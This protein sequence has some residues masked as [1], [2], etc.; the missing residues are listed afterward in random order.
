[1]GIKGPQSSR[2]VKESFPRTSSP[3]RRNLRL[4]LRD[5]N[6]CHS[7]RR[8]HQFQTCHSRFILHQSCCAAKQTYWS[9][10][11]QLLCQHGGNTA[12]TAYRIPGYILPIS[13][14]AHLVEWLEGSVRSGQFKSKNC[15]SGNR[16]GRHRFKQ[17]S[18]VLY[19]ETV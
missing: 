3:A 6:V 13:G 1:M 15:P 11:W 4:S 2:D 14:Y 18:I 10:T 12:P 9:N 7:R 16:W 19:Y 8:Q 17:D 5:H